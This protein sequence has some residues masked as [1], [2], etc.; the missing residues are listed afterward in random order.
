MKKALAV[1]TALVGIAAIATPRV[2]LE[3]AQQR[4]PWNSKVD[5][6]YTVLDEGASKILFEAEAENGKAKRM[7]L[8]GKDVSKGAH[9]IVVDFGPEDDF[10]EFCGQVR[11][12]MGYDYSDG[13]TFVPGD[14][15]TVDLLTGKITEMKDVKSAV[16]FNTEEYKTTKMAFRYVPEGRFRS[17]CGTVVSVVFSGGS[18]T[19]N[20]VELSA[21]WMAVFPVTEAQYNAVMGGETTNS[22]PKENSSW[23]AFRGGTWDGTSGAPATDS[24]VDKLN[25]L[26]AAW[27]GPASYPVASGQQPFDLC[28]SFQWERAARAGTRSDYFFTDTTVEEVHKTSGQDLKALNDYGWY[29][30]NGGGVTHVVGGKKPNAWG[31][32]DVY[33]NVCEQCLDWH[34]SLAGVTVGKDYGGPSS[35]TTKVARGG[36]VDN[37]ASMCSS[38]IRNSSNPNGNSYSHWGFRLVR[39]A[40]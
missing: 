36:A 6:K 3:S 18:R 1:M 22:R 13:V 4:W 28:T 2:T 7:E 33:G 24:F 31:L 20:A 40:K 16:I 14:Y 11:Y 17:N 8:T 38:E 23:N 12:S 30:K 10:T 27:P 9:T 34:E 5:V 32:Y 35:G 21:Y 15:C 25:K 19:E 29:E 37:S 26:V 39:T